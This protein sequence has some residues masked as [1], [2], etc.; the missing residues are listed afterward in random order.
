MRALR[1]SRSWSR[2]R[3]VL[4]VP[5]ALAC[6]LT[7]CTLAPSVNVPTEHLKGAASELSEGAKGGAQELAA[8][9]AEGSERYREDI[10]MAAEGVSRI[11]KSTD[12]LVIVAKDS[13]VAFGNAVGQRVLGDESVQ[14]TL[15]SLTSLAKSGDQ[16]AAQAEKGPA[17]LVAKLGEMQTELT[18]A[19][20]FLSQQR[21]AILEDLHKE[22][23]ALTEAVTRERAAV[24]K[25]LDAYTIKVVQEVAAQARAA[26]GSA[27]L[28][29]ILLVLVLWGLPFAAG[30]LV[31]RTARRK[32]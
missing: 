1:Q 17:L 20:G 30:F 27:L 28:L 2:L 9:L 14:T 3:V 16:F 29:I 21:D 32:P 4:A 11:A 18:K 6:A 31:G 15:R 23:A 12:D 13:P 24:M 19:D 25:D 8:G 26:I 10:R 5:P 7:G 22:R